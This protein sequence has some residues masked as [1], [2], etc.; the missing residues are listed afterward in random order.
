MKGK[1]AERG[2]R[3]GREVGK[4]RGGEEGRGRLRE[5][6]LLVEINEFMQHSGVHI[7]SSTA[8]DGQRASDT[9]KLRGRSIQDLYPQLHDQSRYV[10]T[11]LKTTHL[12]VT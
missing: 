9:V 11:D 6:I 7:S 4:E 8:S 3:R 2:G 10:Y 5:W 1:S 12:R